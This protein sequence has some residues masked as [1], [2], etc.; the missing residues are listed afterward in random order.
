MLKIAFNSLCIGVGGA[1]AFMLGL[2]NSFTDIEVTG[3]AVNR[4]THAAQ[5]EWVKSGNKRKIPIHQAL[6]KSKDYVANTDF[7]EFEFYP[8]F[9]DNVYA[10]CKDAD[11]IVTWGV[12]NA[13]ILKERLGKCVIDF[14]IL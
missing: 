10:A 11:I 2:A 6:G 9:V 13:N 8:G 5:Y 4:E 14:F 1:D 7:K 12:K 3:I